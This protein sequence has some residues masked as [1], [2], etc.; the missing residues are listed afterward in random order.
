MK[1]PFFT[2]RTLLLPILIPVAGFCAGFA[3]GFFGTGGGILLIPI[4]KRIHTRISSEDTS[5][6]GKNAYASALVCM[7]PLSLLSLTLY[8][9]KGLLSFDGA[10]PSIWIPCILGAIPGGLIG[11]HLL[12]RIKPKT[13]DLL[14]TLLLLLSGYRMAFP[15]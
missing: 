12:D 7:I 2:P 6:S 9:T 10:D 1:H 8:V 5:A 3:N 14:F 15:S 13:V 11:A 4:L